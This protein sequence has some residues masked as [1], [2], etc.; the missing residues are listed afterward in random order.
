MDI[1]SG[2]MSIEVQGLSKAFGRR[3]ALDGVNFAIEGGCV[4][5]LLGPN[6]AG[7]STAM[8]IL[9]GYYRPDRGTV[10]LNGY[11]V[12][13]DSLAAR[14][15][16]GYLPEAANGFQNLAVYDFLLTVAE[17]RGLWGKAR[18]RALQR[19]LS[20]LQLEDMIDRFCGELSKGLRQRVWLAQALIHDPAILFLDEPTDGLDPNQ[21]VILR[22][23][24][25]R[26]SKTKIVLF[27]T[28]ILEEAEELCDRIL[29]LN[30]GRL[31]ADAPCSELL[32]ENGRLGPAYIR[33]TSSDVR[34]DA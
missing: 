23:Y 13:T 14:A 32:S 16:H 2:S 3:R 28:H 31:V 33:L 12:V 15:V 21:K 30:A 34:V 17:C 6:G 4:V 7:K 27:S 20:E 24:I 8:R 26:L 18:D 29:V 25:R 19:V 5:G 22:E 1:S 10:K 9:G 11:D